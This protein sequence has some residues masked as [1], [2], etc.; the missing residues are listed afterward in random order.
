MYVFWGGGSVM[1]LQLSHLA[2]RTGQKLDEIGQNPNI[3]LPWRTRSTLA[4]FA[5]RRLLWGLRS[6]HRTDEG[7]AYSRAGSGIGIGRGERR[8]SEEAKTCCFRWQAPRAFGQMN[9]KRTPAALKHGIP[10]FHWFAGI[11]FQVCT[12]SRHYLVS[13]FVSG[14]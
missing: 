9:S 3:L 2:E 4:Q 11:N 14:D 8:S 10:K 6:R 12:S 1:D 13:Y 5:G 7:W